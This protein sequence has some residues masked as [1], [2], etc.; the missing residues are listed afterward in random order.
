[1]EVINQVR[2]AEFGTACVDLKLGH[3][4]YITNK[5]RPYYKVTAKL[6]CSLYI[7]VKIWHVYGE[8]SPFIPP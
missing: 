7:S 6:H 4:N 1:M 8:A 5:G 3:I 2:R